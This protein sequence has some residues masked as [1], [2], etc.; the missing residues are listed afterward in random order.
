[1]S[2]DVRVQ[3][4]VTTIKLH[5]VRRMPSLWRSNIIT[6]RC[7]NVVFNSYHDMNTAASYIAACYNPRFFHSPRV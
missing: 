2:Q 4:V 5:G 1:M 7:P 3:G 6:P